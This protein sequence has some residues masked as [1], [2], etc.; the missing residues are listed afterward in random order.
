MTFM[1]TTEQTAMYPSQAPLHASVIAGGESH[2]RVAPRTPR[3]AAARDAKLREDQEQALAQLALALNGSLRMTRMLTAALFVGAG[4]A[5]QW[6]LPAFAPLP[7]WVSLGCIVAA[8]AV[9]VIGRTHYNAVFARCAQQAGLDAD[10]AK[11]HA[12]LARERA[13]ERG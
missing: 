3:L 10:E 11:R 4:F 2:A 9:S 1:T 7:T 5:A 12:R 6:A 13:W 8:A